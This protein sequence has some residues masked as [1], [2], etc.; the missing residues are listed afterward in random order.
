MMKNSY[1]PSPSHKLI[2]A[3]A[4]NTE[5]DERGNFFRVESVQLM[6]IRAISL[7]LALEEKTRHIGTLYVK[8][9]ILKVKRTRSRH[10]FRKNN[11]YGFNE[12][13]IRTGILFDRVILNDEFG[14]FEIPRE[15][16]LE[17]GTYLDFKQIGFEKQI[18]L[19]LEIIQQ[20]KK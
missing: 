9:R 12:H 3:S 5:P 13:I 14:V 19:A 7:Q 20:Y 10:L 2:S 15:V 8:D 18:F 4:I 1:R 17:K 16:I 11:S 6:L